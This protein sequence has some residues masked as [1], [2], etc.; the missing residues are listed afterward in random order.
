[1][2]NTKTRVF[3][4]HSSKDQQFVDQFASELR[5]F[6]FDVWYDQWEIAVGDS[7]VEKVF[8]GLEASDTL[9]IVLS[10]ASIGSR[11]VKEELL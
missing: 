6:G 11:W 5:R 7:I 10:T 9:V 3:V 2:T 4:S 1:M 8:E